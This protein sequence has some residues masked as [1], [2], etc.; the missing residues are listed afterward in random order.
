[1]DK[2][3]EW[4]TVYYYNL[5]IYEQERFDTVENARQHGRKKGFGFYVV[6]YSNGEWGRV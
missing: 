5:R 2:T 1:M 6:R 4:Y 3:K